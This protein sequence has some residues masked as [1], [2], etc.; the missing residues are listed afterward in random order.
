MANSTIGNQNLE[1][2]AAPLEDDLSEEANINLAD[3]KD[4]RFDILN[5]EIVRPDYYDRTFRYW[6]SAHAVSRVYKNQNFMAVYV[7][8]VGSGKTYSAI[9]SYE[10]I[11]GTENL[12]IENICFTAR[13]FVQRLNSGDM[14]KGDVIM[15]EE[16]GVSIARREWYSLQNKVIGY[17][18]QTFRRDNIIVLFTTPNLG[19]ID[20]NVASLMQG[21]VEMI[22]PSQTGGVFGWAKY[23]HFKVKSATGEIYEEYPFIKKNGQKIKLKPKIS[24]GG[25]ILF[26]LPGDKDFLREYEI[27]KKNF[28]EG[29]KMHLESMLDEQ[30]TMHK[31]TMEEIADIMMQS[32]RMY[33]GTPSEKTQDGEEKKRSLSHIAS[34][35]KVKLAIN[36]PDCSFNKGDVSDAVT[37]LYD[38]G[39]VTAR[40]PRT[41]FNDIDDLLLVK[42]LVK[43]KHWDEPMVAKH[44]NAKTETLKAQIKRWSEKGI[45]R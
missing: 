33:F 32:P 7:G 43:E 29:L 24:Q 37:Y 18:T 22:D 9:A 35:C 8:P 17:I 4:N 25:N 45:W 36:F 19:F 11:V 39:V 44:F 21:Y 30:G 15:F 10:D 12:K 14:K 20:K 3:G 42:R 23:K 6:T 5:K 40:M 34:S 31:L 41:L 16:A 27:K 1:T 38:M 28:V 2:N 13:E 26:R